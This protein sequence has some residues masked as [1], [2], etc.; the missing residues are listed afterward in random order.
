MQDAVAECRVLA[1][2]MTLKH[3]VFHTGDDAYG[4]FF[5]YAV[6]YITYY[7][8]FTE[9]L[10]ASYNDNFTNFQRVCHV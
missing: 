2:T 4:V 9:F 7:T 1:S 5:F 3:R 10:V 8:H 6:L